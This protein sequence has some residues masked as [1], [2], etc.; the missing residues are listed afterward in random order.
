VGGRHGAARVAL[1][2]EDG[3][4]ERGQGGSMARSVLGTPKGGLVKAKFT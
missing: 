4:G 1:Y 3:G 2:C